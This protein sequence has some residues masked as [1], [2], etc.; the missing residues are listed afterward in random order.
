MTWGVNA[1]GYTVDKHRNNTYGGYVRGARGYNSYG[2]GQQ[3]YYPHGRNGY[4]GYSNYHN[5]T[6]YS[7]SYAFL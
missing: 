2:Y 6:I 5:Y 1:R 4:S 7:G 3:P